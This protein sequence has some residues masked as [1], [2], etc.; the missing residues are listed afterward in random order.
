MQGYELCPRLECLEI[1][2]C[3]FLATSLCKQLTSLQSLVISGFEKETPAEGLTD[4]EETG[5]LLLSSL[6]KLQFEHYKYLKDLPAGLHR[7]GSLQVLEIS[8]CPSI[9]GLPA[10]PPSLEVLRIFH[11]SEELKRQSLSRASS[12]LKVQIDG[13]YVN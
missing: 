8:Y 3:S 6:T 12:K 7:L 5:L 11:V 10:L 4:E 2:D 1:S 13:K 9:S